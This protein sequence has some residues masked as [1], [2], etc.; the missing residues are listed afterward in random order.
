MQKR[1]II[2]ASHSPRRRELLALTGYDYTCET[3]DVDEAAIA[4]A[5]HLTGEAL[6]LRLAEAKAA[7]V[8]AKH[9]DC[10]VIGSD[11][12]VMLDDTVYGKPRDAEAAREML[13]ALAGRTHQVHTS[14]CLLTPES[15]DCFLDTCDVTFHPL[16]AA[17]EQVIEDYIASG[18]PFDKAGGYGI[19]DR[20]ALLVKG[21][22]GDY[23]TVMGFPV[24]RCFQLL[25][26]RL[27]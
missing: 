17:L 1:K 2:L 6:C 20:G 19:Q 12:V 15:K 11:T 16:N 21:I 7:A 10:A 18:S 5:E 9:P 22:R 14:V 26:E 27:G 23:Y 8:F 4:R 3:A 25:N 13:R 24:S